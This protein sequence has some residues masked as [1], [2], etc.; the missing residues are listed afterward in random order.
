MNFW[1][2]RVA[3]LDILNSLFSNILR[4]NK[5]CLTL[6]NFLSLFI[7]IIPLHE[8]ATYMQYI[9][10]LHFCCTFVSVSWINLPCFMLRN[11]HINN[12]ES[13]MSFKYHKWNLTWY[14]KMIMLHLTLV[15]TCYLKLDLHG[16]S[17]YD[18]MSQLACVWLSWH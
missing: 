18:V 9:T 17:N 10:R 3:K 16:D 4:I 8:P 13:Y 2:W 1:Y 14:E 5:N 7:T 6:N 12:V 15:L 11:L